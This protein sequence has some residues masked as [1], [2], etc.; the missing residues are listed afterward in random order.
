M[1]ADVSDVLR[2]AGYGCYETSNFAQAGAEARHN[3][4]YWLVRPYLALGPAAHGFID[5]ERYGNHYAFSRWATLLERGRSPEAERETQTTEARA[6]EMM[7]L[8]LR[9][10]TGLKREDYGAAAWSTVIQR[11]GTAFASAVE[12][13]RLE[14]TDHGWRIPAGLRFVADD[15]LAWIE[16]RAGG[17]DSSSR[18]SLTWTP[19]PILHSLAG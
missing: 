1:Y 6:T 13:G 5:G 18:A 3:L 17:V 10:A 19:C 4:V 8:G 14:P 11:Y 16:S 9:L 12:G 7:M 2:Q 15:V